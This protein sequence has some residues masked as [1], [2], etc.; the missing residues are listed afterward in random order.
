METG[1]EPQFEL[2][3]ATHGLLVG[4]LETNRF[5]R[6]KRGAGFAVWETNI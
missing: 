3:L 5:D 4:G 1:D 2:A 6:G